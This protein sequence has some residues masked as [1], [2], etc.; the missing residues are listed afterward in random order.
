MKIP[1]Q[2]RSAFPVMR[3][4]ILDRDLANNG[5]T[6]VPRESVASRSE[7]RS[8]PPVTIKIEL[9][10][11]VI[12][13]PEKSCPCWAYLG[14]NNP[15]GIQR[16]V[17]VL[18]QSMWPTAG[19]LERGDYNAI[20]W[21]VGGVLLDRCMTWMSHPIL[22]EVHRHLMNAAFG[23]EKWQQ[24]QGG[25]WCAYKLKDHPLLASIDRLRVI[26]LEQFASFDVSVD[27]VALEAWQEK[28]AKRK[29]SKKQ[30]SHGT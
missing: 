21:L 14:Q 11:E 24:F 22:R 17:A 30:H 26:G 27:S 19:A 5:H 3:P 10:C 29:G 25:V 23:G 13:A 28:F 6:K 4:R 7:P 9:W 16:L 15:P 2:I 12:L 18:N 20:R 1:T 8:G